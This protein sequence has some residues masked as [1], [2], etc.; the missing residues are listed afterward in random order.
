MAEIARMGFEQ[1]ADRLTAAWNG[2]KPELMRSFEN[3][4]KAYLAFAREEPAYY[5]AMFASGLSPGGSPELRQ[6]ADRAFDLLRDAAEAL[7]ATFP[8]ERRPPA[9]MMALHIWAI[10]HGIASLFGGKGG[11]KTPMSPEELLEAGMLVYLQGL[12]FGPHGS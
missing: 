3:I 12:G 5:A 6:A 11:R 10:S 4:G 7:C 2:G 9:L 8:P 1:F